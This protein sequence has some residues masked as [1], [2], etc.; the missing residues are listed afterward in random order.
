MQPMFALRTSAT[1]TALIFIM[2]APTVACADPVYD[3]LFGKVRP[4]D[5]DTLEFGFKRVD[6]WGADALERFQRCVLNGQT[7]A[8]GAD[9]WQVITNLIGTGN[10]TC[11]VQGMNR[12]KR[13]MAICRNA[14]GMDIGQAMIARGMAVAR[15]DEMPS[16]ARVESSAKQSRTGAWAG[17][18]IDPLLW[19]RGDRLPEH[20]IKIHRWQRD[21]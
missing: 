8:C 3:E 2:A 11:K 1:I 21:E 18:F 9:A 4:V 17:E 10:V 14:S 19:R 16:Y 13:N 12:Y 6:L 15:T 20:Q 7:T 5:G